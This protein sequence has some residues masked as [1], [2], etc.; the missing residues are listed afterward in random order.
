MSGQTQA[1]LDLNRLEVK[2]TSE[3]GSSS[4]EVTQGHLLP[5]LDF[6]ADRDN[7]L[8]F[9]RDEWEEGRITLGDVKSFFA[10]AGLLLVEVRS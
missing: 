7:E 9:V 8:A 1:Q 3:S 2:V 10:Q 4:G 5:T 6:W